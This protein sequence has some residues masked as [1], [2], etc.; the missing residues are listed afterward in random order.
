MIHILKNNVFTNIPSTLI[1]VLLVSGNMT[2][3]SYASEFIVHRD[4][5]PGE[6]LIMDI[7][8][9]ADNRHNAHKKSFKNNLS[10][11]TII[12][13][14]PILNGVIRYQIN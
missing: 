9:I 1:C 11:L 7:K 3:K 10:A 12:D 4:L 8:I 13:N 2:R 14:A 6:G 5:F